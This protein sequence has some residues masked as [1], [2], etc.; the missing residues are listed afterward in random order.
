MKYQNKTVFGSIAGAIAITV[1]VLFTSDDKTFIHTDNIAKSEVYV[2]IL[3]GHGPV[4]DADYT[5]SGKQSPTWSDGLKIYE[6][7][8]N[9]LLALQLSQKLTY[10]HIDNILININ[11]T[12]DMS[13]L[14]RVQKVAA[15]YNIDSRLFLI[16][17]HHNAQPTAKGDY[18]DFEGQKG[19]TSTSTGGATGI[20]VFTSTGYTESDNFTDNYLLP[21][22]K[23]YLPDIHFRNNGK[24]KEANFYVLKYTPCPAVLIEFMFMT[25]YT[26][27]LIIADEYYRDAYTAAICEAFK[28]W[29]YAK[30]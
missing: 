8:S 17:L 28:K 10:N 12:A 5:T 2:G 23:S 20:E 13:L 6:G 21:E 24:A 9:K 7:H 11:C 3:Y 15:I 14:D 16:S 27:C 4:F 30:K 22:L 1:A 29:N 25:T 19:F 26:D 18:T